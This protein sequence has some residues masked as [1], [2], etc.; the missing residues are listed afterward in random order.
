MLYCGTREVSWEA[1]ASFLRK[2]NEKSQ[3]PR[4]WRPAWNLVTFRYL[5]QKG[6]KKDSGG[7]VDIYTAMMQSRFCLACDL[8]DKIYA[9]LGVCGELAALV[10]KPD[11]T[12]SV[13]QV[14]IRAARACL[15][16]S[17][18]T[19]A[20]A[21]VTSNSASDG[22][23]Y[24]RD[25]VR[26]LLPSWAPD[27]NNLAAAWMRRPRGTPAEE[28][29]SGMI[30]PVS[31]C[32][33]S[34]RCLHVR[35]LLVDSVQVALAG[36]GSAE[37]SEP[38]AVAVW[39]DWWQLSRGINRSLASSHEDRARVFWETRTADD[40]TSPWSSNFLE[41]HNN[42]LGEGDG[43]DYDEQIRSRQKHK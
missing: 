13:D 3:L 33:E 35:G 42:L 37:Q 6:I 23:D 4:E 18:S 41:W 16:S 12:L 40:G 21:L 10:G 2:M 31:F 9:L 11:Y 38:D 7:G 26:G 25:N 17:L 8:R 19:N 24:A 14:W 30:P 27:P 43:D 34:S 32:S 36:G 20:L 28:A 1:L 29:S 39:R 15:S 22:D 5:Y